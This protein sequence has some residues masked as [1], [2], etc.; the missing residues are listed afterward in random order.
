M[1]QK[2]TNSIFDAEA[3]SLIELYT[4]EG[5]VAGF[6]IPIYQRPYDWGEKN[7]KRLFEDVLSGLHWRSNDPNSL[8]FLGTIIVLDEKTK[9]NTF[10]GRSLCVID[11]QQRLTTLSLLA[12]LLFEELKKKVTILS[13]IELPDN[14]KVWLESENKYLSL[15]LLQFVTGNLLVEGYEIFPY[16]RIVREETDWRANTFRNKEYKSLI[17][18]YLFEFS[19]YIKGDEKNKDSIPFFEFDF[20]KT[21]DGEAFKKNINVIKNCITN[22]CN[23]IDD[24][25]NLPQ[26]KD[27][28]NSGFRSL[29]DKLPT[30]QSDINRIFSYCK[31]N[32]ENILE[33]LRLLSFSS[34]LMRKVIITLVKVTDEKYGFDIF[35]S[36]NTT[37]EPLTAIQT[38]KPQVI[39]F[40]NKQ[41]KYI[42]SEA[43]TKIKSIEE[44]LDEF[45]G[46]DKKQRI[47]KDL[48]VSFSLYKSGEKISLNLDEQRRY[49]RNS[50][51]KIESKKIDGIKRKRLFIENLQ[52]VSN[53]RKWFWSNTNLESQLSNYPDRDISLLCLKFLKDLNNSLSIPIL[54]RY[55]NA[56][57]EQNKKELFTK[58][59]QCITAFVALR[60]GATGGTAGI[61][62]DLRYLMS[63]GR[64]N[65]TKVSTPICVGL[66]EDNPLVEIPK[67]KEYL[68]E[69][70][71]KKGI[72]DKTSWMEKIISQ[73]LYSASVPLCRFILLAASHNS[74]NDKS[75]TWKLVKQK[76]STETKY[77]SYEIWNSKEVA[78]VEHIAPQKGHDLG[79]D[80]KIYTQPHL[81][82][83]LG[84]LTLLPFEENSAVGNKSWK[85]KK[86]LY[87]AFA[88]ETQDEVDK[89]IKAAQKLGF[90]FSK[91][92]TEILK[93]KGVHLPLA[94]SVCSVNNW[95]RKTI[96]DRSKNIAE[97]AWDEISPWLFK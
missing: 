22:V 8:T 92:T 78:T 57:I 51:A 96:E 86:K 1:S 44:Y 14:V 83:C 40:E 53:Y 87:E 45:T 93:N 28:E 19:S 9:E 31:N 70:L 27:F 66:N 15:K 76:P 56:S 79:W 12:C 18:K 58:A 75:S 90:N 30:E 25:S 68:K 50:F 23:S 32:G 46:S 29:F 71:A 26:L 94:K 37:G 84:N 64:K 35:D 3:L 20:P 52:Q 89:V 63:V 65:K 95:T 77:L 73:P 97:L 60:R 67:L 54:C 62:S 13:T 48:V 85:N 69:W 91:R 43:E 16:P 39:R 10:D 49:L 81:V 42:G 72:K 17:S 47:A 74:R 55:Y 33:N 24:S 5:G 36:L 38:F 82:H 2:N 11:G 4:V 7:I 34:F 41:K 61:D 59:V 88:A 21:P 80:S 6:R